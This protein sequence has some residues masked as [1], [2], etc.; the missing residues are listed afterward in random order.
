M[1]VRRVAP[2]SPLVAVPL[3]RP[4][5]LAARVPALVVESLAPVE[6]T[7]VVALLDFLV[8]GMNCSLLS[9][10]FPSSIVGA[11]HRRGRKP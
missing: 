3:A 6:R 11:T 1:V 10:L 9:F 4:L 2:A 5:T 8:V 7:L